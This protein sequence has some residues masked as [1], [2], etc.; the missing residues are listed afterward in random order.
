MT[1]L[2][3]N[4]HHAPGRYRACGACVSQHPPKIIGKDFFCW[5]VIGIDTAGNLNGRKNANTF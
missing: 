2:R 5:D 3:S 1:F 4:L